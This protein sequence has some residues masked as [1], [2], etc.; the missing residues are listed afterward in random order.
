MPENSKF[1]NERRKIRINNLPGI[2]VFIILFLLMGCKSV[3]KI[4]VEIP[5]GKYSSV[6]NALTHQ[7]EHDLIKKQGVPGV[8]VAIIDEQDVVWQKAF[9]ISSIEENR[10]ASIDDVYKTGS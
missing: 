5:L 8:I 4:P 10:A 6:I 2:G 3:R 7:I 1:N 9:G